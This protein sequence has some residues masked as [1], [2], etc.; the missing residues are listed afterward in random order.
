MT[1]KKKPR[2]L[3][4]KGLVGMTRSKM[5]EYGAEGRTAPTTMVP[6]CSDFLEHFGLAR[7]LT[8]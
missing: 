4:L 7:G 6:P 2:T 3:A 1:K 5:L 8:H